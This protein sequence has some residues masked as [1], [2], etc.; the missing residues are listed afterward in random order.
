MLGGWPGVGAELLVTA[1][2]QNGR[3]DAFDSLHGGLEA[4]VGV[5]VGLYI[6]IL[7]HKW[8]G[9]YL[10]TGIVSKTEIFL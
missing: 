10:E 1:G 8:S 7:K 4:V 6:Y 3:E 2:W 5:V 9:N